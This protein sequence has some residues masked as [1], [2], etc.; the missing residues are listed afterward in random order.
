M[1]QRLKQVES[2]SLQPFVVN[3]VVYTMYSVTFPISVDF[4][5]RARDFSYI[6]GQK[7]AL[8]E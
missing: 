3:R 7:V 5:S 6:G 4:A 2:L 8:V 1:T